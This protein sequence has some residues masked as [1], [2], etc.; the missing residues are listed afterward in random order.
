[1]GISSIAERVFKNRCLCRDDPPINRTGIILMMK[2]RRYIVAVI[3]LILLMMSTGILMSRQ[4]LPLNHLLNQ[5]DVV[6]IDFG[7]SIHKHH[8]VVVG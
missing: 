7:P 8:N 6:F 1:M 5:F 2:K 3:I 4:I